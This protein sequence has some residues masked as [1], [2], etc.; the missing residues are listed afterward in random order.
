MERLLILR[1]VTHHHYRRDSEYLSAL[2]P[3][4]HVDYD[5]ENLILPFSCLSPVTGISAGGLVYLFDIHE[6]KSV[7]CNPTTKTLKFLH[8]RELPSPPAMISC[9]SSAFAYHDASD[10]YKVVR[11]FSYYEPEVPR[12]DFH[13]AELF[14]LKGD[15]WKELQPPL[16]N[17]EMLR[18]SSCGVYVNGVC[19]WSTKDGLYV[20]SFDLSSERFSPFDLPQLGKKDM[21]Y[22]L[23]NVGGKLGVSIQKLSFKFGIVTTLPIFMWSERMWIPLFSVVNVCDVERP[24]LIS[25]NR[26]LFLSKRIPRYQTQLVV[27]D[28]ETKESKELEIYDFLKEMKIFSYVESQVPLKHS[29]PM[30]VYCRSYEFEQFEEKKRKR[31]KWEVWISEKFRERKRE[32]WEKWRKERNM[33]MYIIMKSNHPFWMM[34]FRRNMRL[35]RYL[36]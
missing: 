15:F 13:K 4:G 1:S 9:F 3:S 2:T 26:F 31:E 5:H 12:P 22:N 11:F 25:G 6:G 35:R 32:E 21:R 17:G 24:L 8:R 36:D 23:L 28:L 34:M 29:I 14:S 7:I 30:N 18:A 20:L 10:D 27:Y 33:R 16:M 19:Y